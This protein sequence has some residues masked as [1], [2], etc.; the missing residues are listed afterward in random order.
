M[1]NGGPGRTLIAVTP[2]LKTCGIPEPV[3]GGEL[4]SH[5]AHRIAGS[6][7]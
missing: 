3:V 6:C 2:F 7:P 4:G 5:I 1:R